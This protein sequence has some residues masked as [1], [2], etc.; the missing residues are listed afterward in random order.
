MNDLGITFDEIRESY[1]VDTDAEAESND[2][3]KVN[4]TFPT[5]PILRKRKQPVK[6]KISIFY[7][8]FY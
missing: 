5:I 8:H 1:K 7:L 2:E 6:H 4:P 3:T